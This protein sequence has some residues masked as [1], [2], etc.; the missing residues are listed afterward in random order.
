MALRIA[1]KLSATNK[2]LKETINDLS[3]QRVL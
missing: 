2:L 3:Q 1:V